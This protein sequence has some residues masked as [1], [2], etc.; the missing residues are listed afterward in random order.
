MYRPHV[1]AAVCAYCGTSLEGKR[2]DARYC[3]DRCRYESWARKR[4]QRLSTASREPE[5]RSSN[6]TAK[7][8]RR[9]SRDGRG[10]RLYVLPEDDEAQILAKVRA[11]RVDKAGGAID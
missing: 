5:A 1:N 3:S 10:V 2:R 9:P 4:P 11:A 6:G 8:R 7:T